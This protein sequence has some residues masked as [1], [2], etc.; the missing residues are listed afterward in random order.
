MA[1]HLPPELPQPLAASAEHALRHVLHEYDA[2][3]LDVDL[4]LILVGDAEAVSEFLGHHRPAQLVDT[5]DVAR[6]F[7]HIPLLDLPTQA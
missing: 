3:A 5:P 1:H 4:H 6:G 7:Q 2:V